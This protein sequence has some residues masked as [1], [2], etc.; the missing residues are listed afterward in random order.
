MRESVGRAKSPAEKG[1]E[2]C[3]RR[4]S[5]GVGFRGH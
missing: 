1:G 2:E 4:P 5:R 3:G